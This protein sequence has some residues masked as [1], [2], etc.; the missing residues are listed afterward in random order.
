[1]GSL[2]RSLE[3]DIA[4]RASGA[5]LTETYDSESGDDAAAI[6]DEKE[7][8]PTPLAVVDAAYDAGADDDLVD[9]GI[10]LGRMRISDRVGGM[11]RPR[12]GEEVSKLL[13]SYV[14]TSY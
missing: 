4:R 7:L 1:M 11:V 14:V 12:L 2:E 5:N 10:Q 8:M 3:K 13:H 6:E 9:L